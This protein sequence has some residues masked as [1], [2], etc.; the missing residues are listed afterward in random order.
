MYDCVIWYS[1]ML[2]GFIIPLQIV[3]ATQMCEPK[4]KESDLIYSQ[5]F[6]FTKYDDWKMFDNIWKVSIIINVLL[7]I[8]VV[9]FI[10]NAPPKI[11]RYIDEQGNIYESIPEGYYVEEIIEFEIIN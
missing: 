9:I 6:L 8:G 1:A 5:D 2:L 3:C 7:V 10:C 11:S 4:I